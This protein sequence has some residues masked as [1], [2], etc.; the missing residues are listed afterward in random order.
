[1]DIASPRNIRFCTP[2]ALL[3]GDYTVY[4]GKKPVPF[5][6]PGISKSKIKRKKKKPSDGKN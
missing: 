2:L 5:S 4:Y 3:L 1:M 6:D